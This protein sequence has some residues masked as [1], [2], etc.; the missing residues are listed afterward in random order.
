MAGNVVTNR[1]RS[2]LAVRDCVHIIKEN[3]K[4]YGS[5]EGSFEC[6]RQV[7]IEGVEVLQGRERQF[8]WTMQL[9]PAAFNLLHNPAASSADAKG[10]TR[11]R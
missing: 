6:A 7:A 5:A 1:R 2:F 3:V 9:P 11:T 10:P 4:G 8:L